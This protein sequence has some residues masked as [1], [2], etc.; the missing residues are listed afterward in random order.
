[1]VRTYKPKNRFCRKTKLSEPVFLAML[2][3]YA[4]GGS[5]NET[6]QVLGRWCRMSGEKPV[7]RQAINGLFLKFGKRL[8]EISGFPFFRDRSVMGKYLYKDR[9]PE[10]SELDDVELTRNFVY[11]LTDMRYIRHELKAHGIE[12]MAY[13]S[14][15]IFAD[16][17]KFFE[18]LVS[19]SKQ[20]K[21]LPPDT[22]GY[23][24]TRALVLHDAVH[25]SGLSDREAGLKLNKGL[26]ASFLHNPL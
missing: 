2:R 6:V 4:K 23:E 15:G 25:I 7:S 19:L 21:G 9:V 24:L 18:T 22:F 16:R 3:L 5:I 13:K 12:D 14:T 17:P 20:A 8:W 26:K 1:M 11:K 10:P